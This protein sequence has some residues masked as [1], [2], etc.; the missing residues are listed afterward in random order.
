MALLSMARSR[1]YW[2][3]VGQPEGIKLEQEMDRPFVHWSTIPIKHFQPSLPRLRIP[4]LED[5]INRYLA[6][7]KPLLN[8]EEDRNS[9][10]TC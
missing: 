3:T 8:E 9:E 7:Q 10:K 6:A 2:K 1:L 4:K 5:T